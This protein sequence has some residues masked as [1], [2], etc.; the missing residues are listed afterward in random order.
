MPLASLF[1]LTL[2]FTAGCKKFL[3]IP[4]PVD[5][6]AADGAYIS[7]N[8]TSSVVTGI[9]SN[10][11]SSSAFGNTQSNPEAVGFR[12]ALYTDELQNIR[13]TDQNN[14]SFYTDNITSANFGQW[15]VMYK[16]MFNANIAVENIRSTKSILANRNQWLGESLFC[17]AFLY[18][19]LVNIYGDVPMPLTSDPQVNNKLSRT[20]KAQIYQQIITDLKEA[21]ELLSPNF[22]DGYS[23]VTTDRT[24]PS[25][26]AVTA[27]LARVYLYTGDWANAEAE[28]TKIISNTATFQLVAPNLVF[29]ANSKETIWG[30]APLNTDFPADITLYGRSTPAVVASQSVLATSFVSVTMSQSLINLFEP[31]DT[32]FTNWIKTV[33]TTSAPANGIFYFPSKYKSNVSGTEYNVA[34]RF[35]EQYLIRAE[36]RARLNNLP[37]AATD[38]NAIRT[39]AGLA[40]TTAVS[41]TDM[42]TAILRE[43]QVELF[44]EFGH[45]FFDLKRTG[46]ID[47]VM[48][49]VAPQ[50]GGVWNSQKQI[51]PI[52]VNDITANPNLTQAPGYN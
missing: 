15:Q 1:L 26:F 4:L 42:I 19:H 17:R 30:I 51:W 5:K 35:A 45:R 43:R 22:K 31:G 40:G 44:T 33:T 16:F 11:A 12:T 41:Q 32:R 13:T 50:K 46:T 24:R 38:L 29:L 27:L 3:D 23:N 49:I 48:N 39:R 36:A 14:I 7:D 9:L 21:Q 10:I 8:S 20:P 6:I 18:F 28:S 37:G 52:P 34:L 25:Q 47:A 2:V